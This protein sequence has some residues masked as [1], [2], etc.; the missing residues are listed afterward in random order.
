MRHRNSIAVMLLLTP[1][2]ALAGCGHPAKAERIPTTVTVRTVALHTAS[3]GQ[4]YTATIEPD[5]QVTLAFKAGGYVESFARVR[6]IDARLRDVQAGDFVRKG[7]VLA[8]VRPNDYTIKVDQGRSQLAETQASLTSS[9][10]QVAEAQAAH[11]RARLDFERAEA[12]YASQSMT[13]PDF[14]SAKAQLDTARAKLDAARSQVEVVRARIGT[15]RAQLDEASLAVA[16]TALSAPMDCLVLERSVEVG[17]LVSGG[18]PGFVVAETASMK[19]V[20]GV[21]DVSVGSLRPG[22]VLTVS[23]EAL[24]GESFRGRISNVAPSADPKS[25][26][27]DVEVSIPNPRQTLKV[28][29]IASLQVGG[30]AA[31]E[32]F[33]VVPINAVV[34]SRQGPE[35]YAVLVVEGSDD[36]PVARARDVSL[37]QVFG[38]TVAVTRGVSAGERVVVVGASLV[39]DGEP[40]RV[41]PE[42]R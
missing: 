14:D 27:F 32:Q 26:V 28:G 30:I 5:R 34:R 15:A 16:D 22:T 41:L 42:G 19:A 31:P 13:K 8:R 1:A 4:R 37:G 2:A 23:T 20:F 12:L 18:T 36:L 24:P 39:A 7:T 38:G 9:E 29:M 35:G 40:V 25:R 33:P 21:P 6:G 10:A 3:E 11:E 17:T